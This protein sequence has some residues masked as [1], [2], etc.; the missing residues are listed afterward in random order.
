MIGPQFMNPTDGVIVKGIKNLIKQSYGE[1]NQDYMFLQDIKYMDMS[2]IEIKP[3]DLIVVCGTPWLWDNFQRSVKFMNLVRVF[4]K[5]PK[6]KKLFFG[7]GTCLPL[8]YDNSEILKTRDEVE[9]MKFLYGNSLVTVI[10]RDKLASSR[11]TK[12]GVNNTFLP[13]PAYFCYD[14]EP[15]I[16]HEHN[17][18]VWVDPKLTISAVGWQDPKKLK[19][20]YDICVAFKDIYNPVVVCKDKEEIKSAIAIGLP[21]PKQ[22]KTAEETLELMAKADKV[23]SGRVHCAVPAAT[24]GKATG[25]LPIDTRH[26]VLKDMG[27]K[28]VTEAV[29]WDIDPIKFDKNVYASQYKDILSKLME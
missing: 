18:L 8:G 13:C 7:I 14:I 5:Y 6:T 9:A 11:L 19:N 29:F 16:T 28:A 12:A 20:Y 22:L 10:T 27:V 24:I 1:T 26:Y 21:E 25:I 4:E 3:Y 2:K 17:V 23:L 15:T